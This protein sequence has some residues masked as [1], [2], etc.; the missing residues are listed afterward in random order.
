M[1][2]NGFQSI[3]VIMEIMRLK[4]MNWTKGIHMGSKTIEKYTGNSAW[5]MYICVDDLWIG[6]PT[7]KIH[8]LQRCAICHKKINYTKNVLYTARSISY[9]KHYHLKCAPKE[10]LEL[11]CKNKMIYLLGK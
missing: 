4:N 8:F 3:F 6:I 1:D 9:T 2:K 5:D 7:K 10:L 11:F